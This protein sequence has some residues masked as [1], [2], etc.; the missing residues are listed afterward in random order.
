MF[1]RIF[2]FNQGRPL[3][4]GPKGQVFPFIALR[5]ARPGMALGLEIY[6]IGAKIHLSVFL[7]F[8][9]VCSDLV[10]SQSPK[11]GKKSF[12]DRYN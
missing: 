6:L 2:R 4:I 10:I 8:D 3:K 1:R 7:I 12:R 9:V 5:F 11:T